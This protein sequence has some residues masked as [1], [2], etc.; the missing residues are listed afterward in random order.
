VHDNG[1]R[2]YT[3][4]DLLSGYTLPEQQ[5]RLRGI[6][7]WKTGLDGTMTWAYTHITHAPRHSEP[8]P[9][10]YDLR[11]AIFSFVLRGDEAPFDT[12]SWEAYREGYD[13]AR[14]LATLQDALQQAK[15]A[16]RHLDLA[17]DT[18]MWLE[19][20]TMDADLDAW[21]REMARR[22]EALLNP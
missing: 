20:V 14:Y 10:H 4:M 5:R 7:L 13:D 11:S 2:I 12:L 16:G 22:T 15:N 18:E 8:G 9:L 1:F 21:R 3:Y 6:G 19:G 17:A